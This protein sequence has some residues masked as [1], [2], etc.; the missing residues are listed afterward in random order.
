VRVSVVNA[1]LDNSTYEAQ[2]DNAT[3]L[4]AI[5]INDSTVVIPPLF[6]TNFNQYIYLLP[7]TGKLLVI[8]VFFL[9]FN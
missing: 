9:N 3:V 4:A 6:K 7:H 2:Y 1:L 8:S 5:G